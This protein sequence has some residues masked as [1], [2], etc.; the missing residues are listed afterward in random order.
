MNE[1]TNLLVVTDYFSKMVLAFPLRKA[2]TNNICRRLE[3]E[4]FLKYSVIQ[5]LLCDSGTQFTSAKL[6]ELAEL[7]INS[8]SLLMVGIAHRITPL[9]VRM[10]SLRPV[11]GH[12]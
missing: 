4:V 2:N 1:H 3:D 6:A 7:R 10:G 12:I 9:S 8:E 11:I 5:V